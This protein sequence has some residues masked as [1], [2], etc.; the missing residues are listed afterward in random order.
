M[1]R[2][3]HRF[4]LSILASVA[5]AIAPY[6]ASGST[7]L[8]M[9]IQ[10]LADASGQTIDAVVESTASAWSSDH[11]TIQTTVRFRNVQ[12]LKGQLPDSTDTFELVVPG[13]TVGDTRLVLTGAPRFE[14][15]QRWLL[16]LHPTYNVHP[17]VG[18]FR[19]AFR[20]EEEATGETRVVN[21]AGLVVV[22]VDSRG[23]VR[24]ARP[25]S[26]VSQRASYIVGATSASVV[27]VYESRAPVAVPMSYERFL[28][29]IAPVLLNSKDY[30]LTAP[31][32]RPTGLRTRAVPFQLRGVEDNAAA[33]TN[34]NG[35]RKASQSV[36][37]KREQS[38]D[39]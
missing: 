39:H 6:M 2:A 11:S 37:T 12:Y 29:R 27:G 8:P 15:G 22:G 3:I 33:S 7:V 35:M 17:V 18:I 5:V 4:H 20:V 13:G 19:G 9:T 30:G 24:V 26:P 36:S 14:T 16:F 31:A 32:G 10:Q 28:D 1:H 34:R 25:D 21:P 23:I 38:R